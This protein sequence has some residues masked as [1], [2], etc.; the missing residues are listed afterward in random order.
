MFIYNVFSLPKCITYIASHCSL[1]T[2]VLQFRPIGQT[3]QCFWNPFGQT[4]P[5]SNSTFWQDWDLNGQL[6]KKWTKTLHLQHLQQLLRITA[7]AATFVPFSPAA[8]SISPTHSAIIPIVAEIRMNWFILVLN[9]YERIIIEYLFS[10][11]E[12]D[13]EGSFYIKFLL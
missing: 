5:A 1:N 10:C 4:L 6:L 7:A 8:V 13:D 3:M 9:E 2:L 12:S 11:L